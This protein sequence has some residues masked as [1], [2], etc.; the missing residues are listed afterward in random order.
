MK[1]ER[2]STI[3]LD[4]SFTVTPKEAQA[5]MGMIYFMDAPDYAEQRADFIAGA[6]A[7]RFNPESGSLLIYRLRGAV[8]QKDDGPED[9]ET[10]ALT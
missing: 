5:L 8:D 4:I 10:T 1:P 6:V 3:R 2:K 9:Q 7:I